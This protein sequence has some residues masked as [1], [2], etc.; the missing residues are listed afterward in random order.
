M[1]ASRA[2]GQ[3]AINTLTNFN[4]TNGAW[5]YAGLSISGSTLYGTTTAGGVGGYGVVFS[6][7]ITGGSPT[8][9]ASFNG[10]GGH[11]NKPDSPVLISGS[12]LYGETFN[13]GTSAVGSA[14]YGMVYSVP[15]GG[16]SVTTLANFNNAN[17]SFPEGPLALSGS[18]LYGTTTGGGST[19]TYGTVF[20]IPVGG[21]S[22]HDLASFNESN[23]AS[24][25]GGVIIA[26]N[27]IYGTTST[28]GKNDGG[29]VFSLPIAGGSPVTLASPPDQSVP[30]GTLLLSGST[31]YGTTESGGPT[32]DGIIFSVPV[33]GVSLTTLANFNSSSVGGGSLPYAGLILSGNT[34]YGTTEYGGLYDDGTVFSLPITGGVPTTLASF[35]GS[36]G[37]GPQDAVLLSGNTLYGTTFYGGNS[38]HGTVF[39]ISLS[40]AAAL[41]IPHGQS[42]YFTASNQ[43]GISVT[44]AAGVN[45]QTGG[46][47]IVTSA[48]NHSNRQLLLITGPGLFFNGST[49]SWSGLVDLTNNDLDLQVGD[50]AVVTNQIAEGFNGGRWNGTGGI[51]SSSAAANTTH[52][53]ALGVIQN[54]QGGTALYG[55]SSGQKL[56]DGTTPG[57]SDILIKYTYYGD[58]NLDGK[59]DGSDYSLI[60]SGFLTAATGWINGDFNYDGVVNGSDYTLIDNAFNTQG[61]SLAAESAD[62]TASITAQIADTTSVPEPT[63]AT[64]VCATA[65]G[66]LS[67]RRRSAI[68]LRVPFNFIRPL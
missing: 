4:Y 47:A 61:A 36:N 23:G 11:G 26:G 38:S 44:T 16:G 13:G 67:R 2:F 28:E 45:I 37:R 8:T 6:L 3:Y 30:T 24:P 53:T 40:A 32:D 60:D 56:F 20:S 49:G 34:F 42:Y 9:L 68:V 52:L 29:T 59:V 63:S 14:G 41:Q 48:S 39:A 10:S 57:A 25:Y 15:I 64:L 33:N 31:L 7:P 18:T 27:T 35:N 1:T 66:L 54:N 19:G 55:N 12:T 62:P 43:S 58:A 51:L 22:P 21:G 46:T 5:P 17:G 50:V 65:I